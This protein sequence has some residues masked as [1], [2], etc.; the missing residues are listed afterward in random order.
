MAISFDSD[1][2]NSKSEDD[3]SVNSDDALFSNCD[4]KEGLLIKHWRR[5]FGRKGRRLRI[6]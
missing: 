3:V 1:L 2:V 4:N 5:H 6:E